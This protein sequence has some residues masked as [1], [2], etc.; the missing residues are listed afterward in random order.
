MDWS[1]VIVGALA[2]AGTLA[3]SYFANSKTIALLEYRLGSLEDK[4]QKH[5]NVV[6]RV[7]LIEQQNKAMWNKIDDIAEAVERIKSNA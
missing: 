3:G 6:E 5:N 7:A 4:V 1:T 2:L